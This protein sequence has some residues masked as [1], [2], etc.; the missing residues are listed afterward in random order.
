MC[1]SSQM[2]ASSFS[3]I[4]PRHLRQAR[5]CADGPAALI[6]GTDES[7]GEVILYQGRSSKASWD[8]QPMAQW[9]AVGPTGI[10]KRCPPRTKLA[11]GTRGAACLYKA[12]PNAGGSSVGCGFRAGPWDITAVAHGRRIAHNCYLVK[13]HQRRVFV[14]ESHVHDVQITRESPHYR[15][16]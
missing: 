10:S 13:D 3:A 4:L 16:G 6:A 11:E 8:G 1:Q 7:P 12:P 14:L 2:A 15:I 9:R 5:S